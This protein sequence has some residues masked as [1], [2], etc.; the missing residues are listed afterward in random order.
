MF[1][2]PTFVDPKAVVAALPVA[3]K[4]TVA[5]FGCGAGYFSVEFARAVGEEGNVIALDVLPAALEAME[6]QAKL[7]GL[8]NITTKRANLERENG[9][10][11]A[12]SSVDWVIAK[13]MLFQNDMKDVILCEISRVLRP[14]GYGLIMEWNPE[15]EGKVGPESGKRISLGDMKG[16]LEKIGFAEIRDIPV[17]AYHYAFLVTK[18]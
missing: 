2:S 7:L 9:S 17:G 18:K 15:T 14:G 6:S 13:D 8:R 10:G 12:P 1:S 4:G 5:D 16:L 3:P 11:L